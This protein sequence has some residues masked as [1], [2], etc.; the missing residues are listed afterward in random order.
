MKERDNSYFKSNSNLHKKHLSFYWNVSSKLKSVAE[1]KIMG[2][3]EI[4]FGT[5][6]VGKGENAEN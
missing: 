2:S 1:D 5:G 4:K 6:R 3:Q